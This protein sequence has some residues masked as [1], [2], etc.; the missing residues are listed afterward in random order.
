MENIVITGNVYDK[1]GSGNFI[2]RRL[3][4]GFLSALDQKLNNARASNE[5]TILEIGVGEGHLASH[6]IKRFNPALYEGF[7]IT[8]EVVSMARNNCPQGVFTVGS[9]YNLSDF[10]G[11]HFDII[12]MAEVMEH[13]DKPQVALEEIKKL[14]FRTLILSVP[15]EP[16]WRVLNMARFY[17]LSDLGNTPGHVQHWNRKSFNRL[18]KPYFSI[19]ETQIVFPWIMARVQK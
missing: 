18:L 12:I 9:A 14:D 17:Y 16:L 1:Y 7:D 3:M 5:T 4:S 13:L 10:Q 6:I 2:T 15:Y 11:R 19:V 8:T